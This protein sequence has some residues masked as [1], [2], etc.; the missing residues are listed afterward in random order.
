MSRGK[1]ATMRGKYGKCRTFD[2]TPQMILFQDVE[3]VVFC[4]FC[5]FGEQI[6]I[7]GMLSFCV[8][9]QTLNT[10]LKLHGKVNCCIFPFL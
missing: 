1:F 9:T 2:G 6:S 10:N 5:F 4:F 3:H 7:S 8:V